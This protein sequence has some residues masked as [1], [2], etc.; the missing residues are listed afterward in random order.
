M[1]ILRAWAAAQIL[2]TSPDLDERFCAGI[3][4]SVAVQVGFS[5]IWKVRL[6]I[7]LCRAPYF[8]L[9]IAE[10]PHADTCPSLSR[11]C[12]NLGF[13]AETFYQHLELQLSCLNKSAKGGF[14]VYQVEV[15][16]V[17]Y[18]W[19]IWR[20][21]TANNGECHNWRSPFHTH[22]CTG[23]PIGITAA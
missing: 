7:R 22:L 5:E 18:H 16:M 3:L 13:L 11:R 6:P 1:C 4:F 12:S 17:C 9:F 2:G 19:R 14:C 15:L 23:L 8:F 10:R 21:A 20:P